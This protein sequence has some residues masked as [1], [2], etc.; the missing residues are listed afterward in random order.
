MLPVEPWR[1]IE[2]TQWKMSAYGFY[3]REYDRV[4]LANE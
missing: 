2:I 1:Y 3:A 4:S